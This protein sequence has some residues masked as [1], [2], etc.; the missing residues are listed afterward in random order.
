M[1][2]NTEE[3]D[4]GEAADPKEEAEVLDAIARRNRRR[5][6][7]PLACLLVL[8]FVLSLFGDPIKSDDPQKVPKEKTEK[9]TG[10]TGSP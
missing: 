6:L 8:I 10:A 2:E 7:I 9:T 3:P 1:S 4:F 5:V